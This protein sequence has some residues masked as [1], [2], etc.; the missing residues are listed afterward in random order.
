MEASGIGMDDML[1]L[2]IDFH[3][4]VSRTAHNAILVLAMNASRLV[5]TLLASER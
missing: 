1:A 4:A 3:V 5:P 2:D